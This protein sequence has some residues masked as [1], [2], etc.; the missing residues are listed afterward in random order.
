MGG[1]PTNGRKRSAPK[2][3]MNTTTTRTP[4]SRVRT[5]RISER[6]ARHERPAGTLAPAAV[7]PPRAGVRPRSHADRRRSEAVA[8]PEQIP[9]IPPDVPQITERLAEVA[10][11]QVVADIGIVVPNV[12]AILIPVPPSGR[13]GS[14]S[15]SDAGEHGGGG[16]SED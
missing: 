15:Q 14:R 7:R 5:S 2:T 9:A 13:G 4:T 12:P 6:V 1:A 8:I 11:H 3:S 16:K 10:G